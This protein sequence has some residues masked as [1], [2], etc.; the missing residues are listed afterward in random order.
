MKRKDRFG[1]DCYRKVNGWAHADPE[2]CRLYKEG[3]E[4]EF[5]L[6]Q[7][8]DMVSHA[9]CE[10]SKYVPGLVD[11]NNHWVGKF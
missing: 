8:G 5:V 7:L 9:Q 6:N 3:E 2:M 1:N 10:L 4:I 11:A